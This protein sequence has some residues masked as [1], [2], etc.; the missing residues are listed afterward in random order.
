MGIAEVP[1]C[2]RKSSLIKR[3]F[4]ETAGKRLVLIFSNKGYCL[5]NPSQKS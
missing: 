2:N 1:L 4:V 5:K 3:S